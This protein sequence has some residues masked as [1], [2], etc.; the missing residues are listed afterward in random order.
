MKRADSF[1]ASATVGVG[2]NSFQSLPGGGPGS[3]PSCTAI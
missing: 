2:A 1:C 3:N